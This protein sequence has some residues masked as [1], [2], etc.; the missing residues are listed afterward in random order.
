MLSFEVNT[1]FAPVTLV[2]ASVDLGQDDPKK[3][4]KKRGAIQ[5][6]QARSY[7]RQGWRLPLALVVSLSA[8]YGQ[9]FDITPLVGARYGGTLKLEQQGTPNFEGHL[10]DSVSYG[11]AGG[12][13]F[14]DEGCEGCNLFEFRWIRQKTHLGI[15][16]DPLVPA[17]LTVSAF[18]PGVT[19]DHFLGDLTHEWDIQGAPAFKP[20]ALISLGAVRM[21]TPA[22]STTRFAFG[23]GTGLKI[24]PK[25]KLGFRL[26][27]EYLPIVMHAQV[28]QVICTGGCIVS[29]GG[30]V[31]NQFEVT[32]GPTFRF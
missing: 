25:R 14:D 6:S 21:S 28:Q 5:M 19:L 26:Q 10:A 16:Q 11:I 1:S 13:R 4:V 24:F 31:M 22:A 12:F 23:I 2:N 8:A 20:F 9:R 30:G 27:V 29:I 7:M 3:F 15:E 18:R 32:L 17:P